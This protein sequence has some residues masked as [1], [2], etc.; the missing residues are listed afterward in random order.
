MLQMYL[1]NPDGS[2]TKKVADLLQIRGAVK[3][4]F[5]PKYRLCHPRNYLFLLSNTIFSGL[6]YPENKLFNSEKSFTAG[7]HGSAV[8]FEEQGSAARKLARLSQ[9]RLIVVRVT[10]TYLYHNYWFYV[11]DMLFLSD[12]TKSRIL[13]YLPL[14]VVRFPSATCMRQA[15]NPTS[16]QNRPEH[17]MLR[18]LRPSVNSPMSIAPASEVRLSSIGLHD[19]LA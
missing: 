1:N 10:E 13:H 14:N 17:Q 8:S 19:L 2:V 4:I 5:Q 12:W 3:K 9:I 18:T 16:A 15:E 7:V 11:T 6:K